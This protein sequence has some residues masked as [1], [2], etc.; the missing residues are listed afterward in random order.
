MRWIRG[1]ALATGADEGSGGWR[2]FHPTITLKERFAKGKGPFSK[3]PLLRCAAAAATRLKRRAVSGAR[4]P[5]AASRGAYNSQKKRA[6]TASTQCN[7][8]LMTTHG[9]RN[10][11]NA[12]PKM[13]LPPPAG[14][15][16][17]TPWLSCPRPDSH[18]SPEQ[19]CRGRP[20]PPPTRPRPP[21]A[22]ALIK[23][24]GGFSKA[25]ERL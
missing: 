3:A 5:H 13:P 25:R 11:S 22:P 8:T 21:R 15:C 20:P 1:L 9:P 18:G 7:V 12:W 19:T 2:R 4:A 23:R 14:P 10:C 6:R 24:G 17:Q 16:R